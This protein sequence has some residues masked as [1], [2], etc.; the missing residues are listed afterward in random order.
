MAMDKRLVVRDCHTKPI[1]S[2]TFV[3]WRRE[4]VTAAEDGQLRYW[5]FDCGKLV[6]TVN[7]YSGWITDIVCW[8]EYKAMFTSSNDNTIILNHP[9][10]CLAWQHRHSQL[11]A[12]MNGSIRAY[13]VKEGLLIGAPSLVR[14]AQV[15]N[16]H[17][18]IVKCIV[19]MDA[20][21]YSGG[22]LCRL[23]VCMYTYLCTKPFIQYHVLRYDQRLVSHEI[24][25]GE[26]EMRACNIVKT[27]HDAGINCMAYAKDTEN[28]WYEVAFFVFVLFHCVRG[29]LPRNKTVWISTGHKLITI[30]DPKSGENVSEFVS[31][32]RELARD[33]DKRSLLA[34]RYIPETNEVIATTRR[35][36]LVIWKYEQTAATITLPGKKTFDCLAYNWLTKFVTRNQSLTKMTTLLLMVL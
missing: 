1:T 17:V 28:T 34:L 14:K 6:Q 10:Y 9:V 24:P 2:M 16:S 20:K 11:I 25:P 22:C 19:C 27:A 26:K 29:D 35:R 7:E 15:V 21:V 33:K 4:Y 36:Q 18:D 13:N 23:Y 3:L 5:D 30:F 8:A 32:Y 31:T 12:G